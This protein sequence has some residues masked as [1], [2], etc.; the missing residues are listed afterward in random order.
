MLRSLVAGEYPGEDGRQHIMLLINLNDCDILGDY[1]F[2]FVVLPEVI[3]FLEENLATYGHVIQA[4]ELLGV[5]VKALTDLSFLSTMQL[6]EEYSFLSTDGEK[7]LRPIA[8]LNYRLG[9]LKC[10]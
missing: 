8:Y 7:T 2:E 5:E 4:V 3:F 10:L 1:C 9:V 6:E